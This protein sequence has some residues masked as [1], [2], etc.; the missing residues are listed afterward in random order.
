MRGWAWGM[1]AL[2]LAGVSARAEGQASILEPG[3]EEIPVI[4]T[5]YVPVIES[6]GISRRTALRLTELLIKDI[7]M[8]TPYKVVGS[9]DEA[10]LILMKAIPTP[11]AKTNRPAR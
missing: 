9:P 6:D 3:T 7:E 10:D 1:A 5:I 11:R 8:R 2:L 4:R